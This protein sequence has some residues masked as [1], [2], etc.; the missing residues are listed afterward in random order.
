MLGGAAK[1]AKVTKAAVWK[2]KA[3]KTKGGLTK[4]DI[5]RIKTGERNGKP[6]YKYVSKK[7]HDQAKHKKNS[8]ISA[9]SKFVSAVRKHYDISLKE[10]MTKASALKKKVIDTE[11]KFKAEMK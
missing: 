3:E 8:V 9:W 1:P 10:A 6:V 11:A 4:S 2:G 5:L 7:K